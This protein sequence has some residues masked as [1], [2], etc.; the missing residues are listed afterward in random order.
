MSTPI[1]L[2][3]LGVDLLSDETQMPSGTVRSAVNVDIDKQGQFKRRDG[4][5]D[6]GLSGEFVGDLHPWQGRL[7][8]YRNG[9]LVS[10]DTNTMDFVVLG[11]LAGPPPHSFTE[12]NG[13]LY[14]CT[15]SAVWILRENAD[16]VALSG[17]RLPDALPNIAAN[18]SGALTPGKYMAAISMLDERGE[19]SQALMLGQIDVQ[20]GLMLAGLV[21]APGC[22]WR[23]YLT[24]PDG[25][26]LYLSEEFDAVFSQ[27][28]VGTYPAGKQCE[29]L[30]MEPLPGGS[31]IRADAGRIYVARGDTLWFSEPLRP[32]LVAA[33]HNFVRFVGAIGF[34]EFVDGGCYVADDRGVWWLA[35]S[36]P[37]EWRM[38]LASDAVAVANSSIV[39]PSYRVGALQSRATTDCAVWLSANGYMVGAAGGQVAAL[40]PERIRIAP[41]HV[42]RSIFLTRDGI[43][44]IITLTASQGPA[45]VFGG[46]LDTPLQ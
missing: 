31:C 20:A 4:Y 10:I 32:H 43:N 3:R 34:V 40:H 42:G 22:K 17:S 45:P 11:D 39:L 38:A 16:A 46:A 18:P 15:K 44:Q 13:A 23:L 35:G 14:V 30:H 19:E 26:V 9:E 24:P 1:P 12:Y 37:T 5:T 7:I 8:A 33:R 2:P 25:D 27:Y 41:G 6:S 36:D 28:A 21:V 29:T